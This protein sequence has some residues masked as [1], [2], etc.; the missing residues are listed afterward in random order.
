L[1]LVLGVFFVVDAKEKQVEKLSAE[2][3]RLRIF[4]AR[5]QRRLVKPPAT[6]RLES[7]EKASHILGTPPQVIEAVWMQ[8]NGPPDIETGSIGKTDYFAE[9]FPMADWAALEAART[10]NRMAFEWFLKTPE[11]KRAYPK[12]LTYASAPYTALGPQ[13]QKNWAKYVEKFSLGESK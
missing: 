8:E 6:P 4:N 13:E 7:I 2:N 12:F 3:E 5:R 9:N 10:M 11:G 1:L